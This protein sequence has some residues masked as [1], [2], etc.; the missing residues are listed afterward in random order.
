MYH[1]N[2]LYPWDRLGKKKPSNYNGSGFL[3]FTNIMNMSSPEGNSGLEGITTYVVILSVS[4]KQ[5][6]VGV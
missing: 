1:S 6:N 2:A 4:W 5:Q 3:Y